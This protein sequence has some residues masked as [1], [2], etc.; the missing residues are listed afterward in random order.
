MGIDLTSQGAGTYWYLP[1]ECF[2]QAG[3]SQPAKISNKVD[4]WSTGVIFFELLF[5]RRPFGHGQSQ[6]ALQRSTMVGGHPFAVEI[7]AI[8]KVSND[9]KDFL[10]RLLTVSRE[11]RPDV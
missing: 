5:N 2:V 11:K 10:R 3:Q 4:V 8:P 6:E 9:E 1:P 7:P